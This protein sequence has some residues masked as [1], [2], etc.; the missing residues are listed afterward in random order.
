MTVG[1]MVVMAVAM[2]ATITGG[3]D[4]PVIIKS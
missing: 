2:V 1:M 3:E 4:E